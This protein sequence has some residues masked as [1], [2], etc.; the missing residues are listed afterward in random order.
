MFERRGLLVAAT[1]AAVGTLAALVALDRSAAAQWDS[2]C[3]EPNQVYSETNM[4]TALN[5]I[6]TDV[7][8][9]ESGTY[10]GTVGTQTGATI[11]VDGP[12]NFNPANFNGSARLFVR[13]TALMPALAIDAEAFLE[14]EGTVRFLAQIN[15]NG[16]ATAINH[17]GATIIV[18]SPGISLSAGATVQND[19]TITVNGSVN[20][21]GSTVTNSST[22]DLTI[23]GTLTMSGTLSNAGQMTVGGQLTVNGGGQLSN[24]CSLT[25][26]GLINN[27]DVTNSG[28]VQLGAAAFTNNGGASFTQ[29]SGAITVG[30]DFTNNAS[31]AGTGAYLFGGNTL[32]QG[33]VTGISS[34]E[35]IVF[36][37]T[38]ST[39]GQI[40]DTN[41]GTVS[42]VVRQ[43]VDPPDPGACSVTPPTTTTTSRRPPRRRCLPPPRHGDDHDDA[44]A[45]PPAPRQRRRRPQRRCRRPP[46]AQTT[47]NDAAADHDDDRATHH[48]VD[49]H[50]DDD[51][52]IDYHDNTPADDDGAIDDDVNEFDHLDDDAGQRLPWHWSVHDVDHLPHLDPPHPADH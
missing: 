17:P 21:N 34:A 24:A 42:N 5:L 45:P 36:F 31:V 11:C 27:D 32:N 39:G 3:A 50:V 37:D 48:D 44:A 26:A 35:P 8:L 22:G 15:V 18:D 16:L 12:A 47:T 41:N 46:P 1:V 7:V 2:E 13:G 28:V 43:P 25:A 30:G 23:T 9:F 52:A 10:T 49:H 19:G 4:P 38:T 14:N 40:F 33:S 29:T 20:L 6:S 51:G